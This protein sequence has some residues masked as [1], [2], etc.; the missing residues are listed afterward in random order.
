MYM[1]PL[2]MSIIVLD[3]NYLYVSSGVTVYALKTLV[4]LRFN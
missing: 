1:Y 2:C 4:P 3:I